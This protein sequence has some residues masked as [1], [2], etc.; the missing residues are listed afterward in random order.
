MNVLFCRIPILSLAAQ[1]QC[2]SNVKYCDLYVCLSIVCHST[3]ISEKTRPNFTKFSVH[4][5]CGLASV[6]L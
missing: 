4:V 1:K 5:T 6:I 3:H 2:G